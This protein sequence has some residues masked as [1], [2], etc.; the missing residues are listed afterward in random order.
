MSALFV[1]IPLGIVF[2]AIAAAFFAFGVNKGQ[3]ENLDDL[4][5]RLPDDFR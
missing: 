3:F 2:V 1:L 4:Q 5:N